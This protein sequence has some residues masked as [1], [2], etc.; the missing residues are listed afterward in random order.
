MDK[1]NMSNGYTMIEML[2]VLFIISVLLW[3]TVP[4]I[5]IDSSKNINLI[6]N[7]IALTQYEAINESEYCYYDDYNVSLHYNRLG[8]VNMANTFHVNGIDLV[9][10][11]STGRIYDKQEEW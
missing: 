7:E 4:V 6:I 1:P 5:K 9:V 8:N 3:I 10:T 2:F 11:L